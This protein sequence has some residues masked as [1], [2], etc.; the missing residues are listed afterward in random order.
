MNYKHPNKANECFLAMHYLGYH[1]FTLIKGDILY[2]LLLRVFSEQN[3]IFISDNIEYLTSLV[4]SMYYL[5]QPFKWPF[6]IIPNLPLDLIEVIDS[7]VPFLIGLLFEPQKI[8]TFLPK[9]FLDKNDCNI[10]VYSDKQL[11]FIN[12]KDINFN[13]PKLGNMKKIIIQ[14]LSQIHFY[15]SS[16]RNEDYIQACEQLYKNIYGIIKENVAEEIDKIVRNESIFGFANSLKFSSETM[17]KYRSDSLDLDN[18][19]IG[20]NDNDY[21]EEYKKYLQNMFI[22]NQKNEN[23]DFAKEFVATQIFASYVD[24]VIE[25]FKRN[26]DDDD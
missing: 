26:E 19:V 14:N 23:K 8:S 24:D 25:N 21:E 10:V 3:I 9:K 11:K 6:I 5:I 1:M 12:K 7:P 18:C 17:K 15:A 20:D 2:D 4:L 16:K 22:K 13:E